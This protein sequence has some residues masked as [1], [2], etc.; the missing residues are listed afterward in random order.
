MASNLCSS[1]CVECGRKPLLAELSGKPVEF[2]RTGR[3]APAMGVRWDCPDC[4]TAYFVYYRQ[5][6]NFWSDVEHAFEEYV[7]G[8]PRYPNSEKGKFVQTD[9]TGRVYQTGCYTIDLAYYETGR[10]E[11]MRPG[12]EKA[13]ILAG[14]RPP[15]R[16][17]EG[18]AEECEW[19][20]GEH[21]RPQK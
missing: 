7:L 10:D 6:D 17:L 11:P 2:R 18:E 12:P 15:W 5:K 21:K 20:W 8:D 14:T 1:F 16:L 13:E 19:V 9:S 4:E 3:Y